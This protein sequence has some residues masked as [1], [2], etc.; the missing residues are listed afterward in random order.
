MKVKELIKK[1][2]ALPSQTSITS[3]RPYV[4][5]KIVLGLISQ[6][7]EPQKVVVPQFVAD[8]IEY[9]K[10]CSGTLYGS[11]TPFSYYGRAITDDF[12]GDVT[13]VLRWIRDNSEVYARAW[14]DGYE[15]EKE[16]RY[17]VRLKNIREDHETLNCERH[18]KLW[19]FSSEEETTL[20]KT[21]HTSKELEEA[22]FG[23][24]F[25]CE[26]IEVEEAE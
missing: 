5:K 20:Y 15:V 9:F 8:W 25:D 21:K 1:I 10:K 6:L 23:W 3:I 14:L 17:Y 11:T 16:K 12:E 24:V 2:E 13:E 26:G 4:D 19:N 18:S 22:G 7:D